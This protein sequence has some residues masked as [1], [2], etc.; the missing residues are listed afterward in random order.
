MPAASLLM[1]LKQHSLCLSQYGVFRAL[2]MVYTN[3]LDPEAGVCEDTGGNRQLTDRTDSYLD[4]QY[5]TRCNPAIAMSGRQ[6][7]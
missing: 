1:E 7:H 3:T 4:Q 5:N 6:I 2:F